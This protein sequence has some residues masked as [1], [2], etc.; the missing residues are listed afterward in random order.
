M[1][2]TPWFFPLA[3]SLYYSGFGIKFII[4]VR[5]KKR[6]KILSSKTLSLKR[7]MES[8]KLFHCENIIL[9]INKPP[10]NDLP[11]PPR[12]NGIVIPSNVVNPRLPFIQI[13]TMKWWRI[14]KE[15]LG[16]MSGLKELTT[17]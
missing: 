6:L 15:L 7:K 2:S 12:T 10:D 13:M 4:W 1:I 5:N 3:I 11:E 16:S 9:K 8:I 14:F 17:S